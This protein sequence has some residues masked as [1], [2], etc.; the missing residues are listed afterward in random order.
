MFYAVRPVG[1]GALP[2]PPSNLVTTR[3]GLLMPNH[4][5]VRYYEVDTNHQLK[6]C[7]KNAPFGCQII[8]GYAWGQREW[9]P[10]EFPPYPGWKAQPLPK[11]FPHP[12][13]PTAAPAPAPKPKATTPAPA[14]VKK[15]TPVSGGVTAFDFF[16]P[17]GLP[18]APPQS[19]TTVSQPSDADLTAQPQHQ[20]PGVGSL[21]GI[22]LF[23]AIGFTL[24][25]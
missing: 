16:P 24:L 6:V 7:P 2:S 14:P 17:G 9:Y 4:Q 8:G 20:T 11:P 21:I 5:W 23:I 13:V 15:T 3:G 25:R 22:G 12:V 18:T 1:L 10:D 19:V